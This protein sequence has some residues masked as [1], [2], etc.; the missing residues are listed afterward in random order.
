MPAALALLVAIAAAGSAPAQPLDLVIAGGRVMDPETGLDAVRDVG[1]RDGRIVAISEAPLTARAMPGGRVL[2]A[3]G[4]VVAPGFIDLHAHGQSVQANEYQVRDGVTTALELEW[5]YPSVAGWL[6][7]R[8]GR[9]IVH[10]GASVSHGMVRSFA[11]PELAG[12]TAELAAAAAQEDPLRGLQ[13]VAR[14]GFYRALPDDRLPDLLARLRHGLAEGGLGIGMAHQYYPGASRPEIFRVFEL[15]AE[16]AAPIFTHVR[17]MGLDGIQEVIANAAAT[18]APLHIVHVNSSS[19]RDLPAALDLIAGAQRRGVD[20]TTEA[21]PYT[22]GSTG[23]ES[24]IFDDGWQQRLGIDYGDVQW[25]ETGER[26]TAES[27]ARYRARGGVVILHMMPQEL[28]DLAMATPFVIIAS[29]GMPY[30][31]GAHPRSAGTFSRVLGRH[32]RERGAVPLMQALERMTLLPARR[33]EGIAPEMRRKGRLQVEADADVVAFDPERILDT[34]T[35]ES[36]PS[37]SVGI[38]YV[39][40]AGTLVVDRGATVPGVFPGRPILG[41]YAQPQDR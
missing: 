11:M 27:F 35:F 24:A 1:I 34:A 18:G 31:P 4:L 36:G 16:T 19:L 9:S 26:L 14:E 23:I 15:A 28:I 12:R 13:L 39:L 10:Y 21:Y 30:A 6:E 7:Y 40:V 2:D 5:G 37:F 8:R 22:A 20:V 29:D 3:R 33:L 25:Q 38:E 17:A 32:V 41:R